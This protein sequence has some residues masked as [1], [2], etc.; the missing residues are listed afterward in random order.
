M[1]GME[2]SKKNSEWSYVKEGRVMSIK[3]DVLEWVVGMRNS[4][5]VVRWVYVLTPGGPPDRFVG[6]ACKW[7]FA[8]P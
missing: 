1:L 2:L 4:L 7:A 3:V 5:E 8:T 6:S